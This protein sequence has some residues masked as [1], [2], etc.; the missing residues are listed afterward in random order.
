M[1][2]MNNILGLLSIIEQDSG[3]PKN[4]RLR[5]KETI[6][7]LQESTESMEGVVIDKAIQY[8]DELSNDPNIPTFTRT[9]LW[10]AMSALESK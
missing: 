7:C 9:Q 6:S 8:L 10:S 1:E 5:I 4:V 2:D 3:V